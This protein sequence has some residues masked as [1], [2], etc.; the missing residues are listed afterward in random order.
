MQF[1]AGN[2]GLNFRYGKGYGAVALSSAVW[3][4]VSAD[5]SETALDCAKRKNKVSNLELRRIEDLG[6][7]RCNSLLFF[8]LN[9]SPEKTAYLSPSAM[10]EQCFMPL[11]ALFH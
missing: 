4:V 10:T 2:R 11:I 3:E 5:I 1:A 7:S 9:L 6:T 8:D